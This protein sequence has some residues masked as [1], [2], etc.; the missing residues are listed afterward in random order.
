M[1][2]AR[3]GL[4]DTHCHLNDPLFDGRASEV[5][6]RA[7]ASGVSRIIIPGWDEESSRRA[8]ELSGAFPMLHAAVGLHPWQADAG[9]DCDWLPALLADPHVCAIGEIGI[10]GSRDG[11]NLAAQTALFRRQLALAREHDLP[12]LLHCVQGWDRL[13]KCLRETPGI[14][15]VLHAFSGSR[16]IMREL[17]ALGLFI[18]LSP[19]VTRSNARRAREATIAVPAERMLLESDAPFM[20]FATMPASASEPAHLPLVLQEIA[21][22]RGDTSWQLA[23]QCEDNA[24]RLFQRG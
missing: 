17:L 8:L 18:G 24:R 7:H 3:A 10:D 21:V 5:L 23:A 20:A 1:R 15:G 13:L 6:A 19:L 11:A 9:A 12:V 16:E 4:T 2:S 22:L 14:R